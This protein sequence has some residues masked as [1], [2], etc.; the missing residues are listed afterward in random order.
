MGFVRQTYAATGKMQVL[1]QEIF[2]PSL[3]LSQALKES[4][5][6]SLSYMDGRHNSSFLAAALTHD[7]CYV[8]S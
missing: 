5:R 3:K 1:E 8:W 2:S 7:L 6:L 4:C